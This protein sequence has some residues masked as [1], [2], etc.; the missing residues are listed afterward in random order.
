[1]R[2][3]KRAADPY[4]S[5]YRYDACIAPGIAESMFMALNTEK[6]L[7]MAESIKTG[8]FLSTVSASV[9]PTD[10]TNADTFGRDYLSVEMMSKYPVWDLGIDRQ[11]VALAKFFEAERLCKDTNR[12]LLS[13]LGRATVG[14][15]AHPLLL[16][17]MRKIEKLLGPFSWPEAFSYSYWG[18][19][20]T[21]RLGRVQRDVYYK[22]GGIPHVTHDLFPL[23]RKMVASV[24]GWGPSHLECVLGNK[25][26]TVPKNA[27]TDRV[28]AIEPEL[29]LIV[30]LGIGRMIRKRLNRVGLLLNKSQQHNA[31][32]AQQGSIDGSLATIDL[33]MASDTVSF[34]IVRTLLPA[35]WF[36]ALEQSRSPTGVLPSGERLVY[37]KFSS[38][39]NGY[40]F[41]LETLIF[42]AICS[43]VLDMHGWR[44]R[45]PLVYGDDIVVPTQ[46]VDHILE[47]IKLIGFVPNDKKTFWSGPFRESCGKHYFRGADVTPFYVR[48]PVDCINRRYWLANSIKRWSRMAYGLDSTYKSVYDS[49]VE[50]IPQ[51]LRFPIPDGYGD[52]GL[53]QDL[54]EANPKCAAGLHK[55]VPTRIE[56]FKYRHVSE[57][58]PQRSFHDHQYLLK[59]L[60]SLERLGPVVSDATIG[61]VI[62]P[63]DKTKY[64][65]RSGIAPQWSH[66][67]PWL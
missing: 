60:Y 67:G 19:G 16:A 18:R 2:K 44:G 31:E 17:A 5:L 27:K 66:F 30:Q 43:A 4:Q 23:A 1:M 32:A 57:V 39:G 55:G 53:V 58:I 7:E 50:P 52:G 12:R 40:N 35:R 63:G 54:D 64:V 22:F 49:V 65:I 37:Q 8:N 47:A 45:Q 14:I 56:G 29:N 10:Y 36:E 20:A 48:E 41:E 25:V 15:P 61:P 24:P 6:S 21:T 34:E 62:M 33:S 13:S 38:M 11:E 28:I 9:V 26:T 51:Q 42:W 59:K 46:Y 3:K